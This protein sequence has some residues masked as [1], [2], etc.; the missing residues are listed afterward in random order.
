MAG[1]T[2][3]PRL[4]A[5]L[6][7]AL[8]VLALAGCT[9]DQ[10]ASTTF[11]DATSPPSTSLF[12]LEP[13][14]VTGSSSFTKAIESESLIA[15]ELVTTDSRLFLFIGD[16]SDQSISVR[17]SVDGIVWTEHESPFSTGMRLAAATA[18]D[19]GAF[20]IT[21]GPLGTP[22][23]LWSSTDG[24]LWESE[25]LPMA[26]DNEFLGFFGFAFADD[27]VSR[28]VTGTPMLA[29]DELIAS[30]I[31]TDIWDGYDPAVNQIDLQ[32][33]QDSI[34]IHV[35]GPMGLRLISTTA[36]ALG[37]SAQEQAWIREADISRISRNSEMWISY[38]GQDWEP[39]TVEGA[40]SIDSLG[41]I[42]GT[43]I[44]GGLTS[45]GTH[46]LWWTIDGVF[47][48]QIPFGVRPYE[49][50]QW[51]DLLI[52]PSTAIEPELLIS[53]D[54][55]EWR[56]TGLGEYLEPGENWFMYD[57]AASDSGVVASLGA[58]D[59]SGQGPSTAVPMIQKDD[60]AV[61]AFSMGQVQVVDGQTDYMWSGAVDYEPEQ[62]E[63][64]PSTSTLHLFRPDGS[65]LVTL[66]LDDLRQLRDM[67]FSSTN[68][69]GGTNK[70]PTLLFSEDLKTWTV[71][72]LAEVGAT[73]D[74]YLVAAI[75]DNVVVVVRDH[76]SS[77]GFSVWTA[78]KR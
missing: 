23:T 35:L 41:T 57:F 9:D 29:T 53:D 7:T 26:Y 76:F 15:Q 31:K 1:P 40:L 49:M 13:E 54:G 14:F 36:D 28:V 37:F 22:P 64:D 59:F 66:S 18:S 5:S 16:P 3:S 17:S 19:G 63:F 12:D 70:N 6:S 62:M 46:A 25:E 65:E 30:K 45:T 20:V 8:V 24:E 43:V 77:T 78:P 21:S 55:F 51:G 33:R 75:Q 73:S 39:T 10:T 2:T 42:N 69:F 38:Q 27:G 72:N 68:T 74:P 4:I 44:G 32:F 48:E 56:P 47:W 67:F 52:G 71:W 60:V 50:K 11:T 34:N 58:F 61:V